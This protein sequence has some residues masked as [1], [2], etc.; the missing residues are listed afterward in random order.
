MEP[1]TIEDAHPLFGWQMKSDEKGQHQTAYRIEVVREDIGGKIWDSGKVL[2]G[3]SQNIKYTGTALQP[4]S[5]YK[6]RLSVWDMNGQCLTDSSRFETGLMFPYKKAWQG[7]QWIGTKQLNLDAATCNYFDI[8]T[9][10]HIIEGNKASFILGANDFRLSDAFQNP[11]NISGENYIRVEFDYSGKSVVIN[12][13]R[14]GYAPTD[15]ADKPFCTIGNESNVNELLSIANRNK[16]FRLIL[17]VENSNFSFYI[18]GNGVKT[19]T[20]KGHATSYNIGHWGNTHDQN[21]LPHLGNIGFAAMPHS[22]VVYTD[23]EI[24]FSGQSINNLAFGTDEY[25]VFNKIPNTHIA[26]NQI[27]VENKNDKIVYGY[28][29]PSHHGL[30]MVRTAFQ[31]TYNKQIKRAKIY[32]TSMG[33]YELFVNGQRIGHDWFA[34]GNHQYRELLGYYAYDVTGQICDGNNCIGAILNSGWFTGYMTYMTDNYNFWGDNE[35]LL[36]KL[37]ITYTDGSKQVIVT[38]PDTWRV[39]KDGPLRYGSFFQGERYDAN[40]EEAVSGWTTRQYNDNAWSRPDIIE[41]HPWANFSIVARYDEPV[42]VRETLTAQK[43]C[44]VHSNDNHTYIYD[45]GTNMVGVVEVTIP[46]GWL[47]KGDTVIIRYAEQLYPGLKGDEAYYVDTYGKKGK[48]IAGRPLYETTRAALSTD[49]YIA[50][51]NKGVTIRPTTT[52]H[53]FRYVQ[54]TLP[55]HK[56]ALPLQY[57]KGLVLSSDNL[58]TGRYEAVTADCITGGLVN[59]LFKNIQRSQ[60]G[61]FFTIPTDCPQR[62]ERMGWTGDAQAYVRT[63]SYNSDVRNFFREWMRML[64]ADCSVGKDM[65]VPGG[66][67]CTIPTY[68]KERLSWF[69]DGTTWA[70]AICMVPWQ[71]FSQYGDIQIVEENIDAMMDW[72]NGMNYYELSPE[73]PHLSQRTGGLADWLAM[74]D[75]TPAEL[76]NN[77]IYIYM[78]EVTARMAQAIGRTD[79]AE[80]LRKRHTLAKEEWNNAFVDKV[81]GKTKGLDGN[82]IHSQ[83]SYATALNFNCFNEANRPKA[84][85]HLAHLAAFPTDSGEGNKTFPIYTITTGF[86]GTPNILPALSRAGKID[87]AYRMFTCRD[88][89]SW[90]YPVTKGATSIWERWNGYEM[91]FGK[92]KDNGMNSFNHFALGS[93]GQWMYEYQLGITSGQCGYKHFLLQP[94]VG[95]GYISLSGSYDSN[96]GTIYSKWKADGNGHMMEYHVT[97]PANTSAT[98]YLPIIGKDIHFGETKGTTFEGQIMHN[99]VRTAKYELQ[100][101]TYNFYIDDVQ[102]R[103][104]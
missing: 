101:G 31:T 7:A 102:I 34:P 90:L 27:T 45:I 38:N 98:L 52:Y 26:G 75:R 1:L 67:G 54:I 55:S 64:R 93:V 17:H 70:A 47:E 25:G 74:D 6:W 29:D 84:E 28:V 57:V 42:R 56:G 35:A 40:R 92:G 9:T 88:Y 37:V 46:D 95:N 8:G 82:I 21:T 51:G 15:T 83:T 91:A 44:K 97:I 86:S 72:H 59:Q 65:E 10:L 50:R 18:N 62:N 76:V 23:Y 100:S 96:Y 13:Y 66:I 53:G 78:M 16:P 5:A 33:A 68:S 79:Y 43:V 99:G 22:K 12:I 94:M 30:T 39:Y 19:K 11:D 103:C 85:K 71:L 80:I 24:K 32:V 81:T 49:F 60:L 61:N 104:D 77:A 41:P 2:C 69:P 73:Y 36:A 89:T 3:E 20:D 48:K 87:E 4:E 63:A 14:V 58:P